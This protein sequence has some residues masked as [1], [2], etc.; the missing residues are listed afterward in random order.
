MVP[1]QLRF[2][3]LGRLQMRAADIVVPL[4]TP[5]QRAVLALLLM[6]AVGR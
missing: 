1:T 5:K 4:G 3:L 2:G 6:N